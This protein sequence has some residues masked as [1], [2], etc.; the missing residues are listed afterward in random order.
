[1]FLFFSLRITTS[2][3]PV[4]SI[5][6][7]DQIADWFASLDECLRWNDRKRQRHFDD[8]SPY[9][10]ENYSGSS[11]PSSGP[12]SLTG[13]RTHVEG[14]ADI[15]NDMLNENGEHDD[16]VM[17]ANGEVQEDGMTEKVKLSENL[18]SNTGLQDEKESRRSLSNGASNTNDETESSKREAELTNHKAGS[19]VDNDTSKLGDSI[20]NVHKVNTR[21]VT[22][23]SDDT[24]CAKSNTGEKT[25]GG[26]QSVVEKTEPREHPSVAQQIEDDGA[27]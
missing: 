21:G 10:D 1:M 6:S 12:S 11:V 27:D 16:E 4:P 19:L 20:D 22:S 26:L 8:A 14:E 25:C 24:G 23:E 2:I 5:C 13:E 9:G 15:D 7:E 3:Y 18:L 17:A